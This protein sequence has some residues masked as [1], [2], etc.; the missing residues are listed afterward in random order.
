[1]TEETKTVGT[2]LQA[3]VKEETET[4]KTD[5][6]KEIKLNFVDAGNRQEEN[7]QA[8]TAGVECASCTPAPDLAKAVQ[9]NMMDIGRMNVEFSALMTILIKRG[10]V[11]T[12]E[13]E[14][15]IKIVIQHMNQMSG[16]TNPE[17]GEA[18]E[19]QGKETGD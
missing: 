14:E 1:M 17:T 5:S 16:N 19:E 6:G 2:E 12:Q 10:V 18:N 15:A 4:L 7:E 3:T 11:T 8:E 13:M 9:S